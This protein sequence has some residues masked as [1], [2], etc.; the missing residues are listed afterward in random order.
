[1][2]T[3]ASA[4]IYFASPYVAAQEIVCQCKKKNMNCQ[5]TMEHTLWELAFKIGNLV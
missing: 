5:K 3:Q 2:L 1:M 4:T